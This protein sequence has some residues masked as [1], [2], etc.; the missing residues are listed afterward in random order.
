MISV[1]VAKNSYIDLQT[2]YKLKLYD[3]LTSSS[4]LGFG[5]DGAWSLEDDCWGSLIVSGLGG[6]YLNLLILIKEI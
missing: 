2:V 6:W 5:S 4:E 1:R 3:F